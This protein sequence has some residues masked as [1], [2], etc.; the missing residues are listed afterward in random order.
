[1]ADD[2]PEREGTQRDRGEKGL[3]FF[4]KPLQ[5][6]EPRMR[7]GQGRGSKGAE[8]IATLELKENLGYLASPWWRREVRG[9]G[10]ENVETILVFDETTLD[11][12]ELLRML[13]LC[14][15]D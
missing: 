12:V 5:G 6:N 3:L 13:G 10:F 4:S 7:S 2:H 11:A 8:F 9:L 1:L 14:T 15:L